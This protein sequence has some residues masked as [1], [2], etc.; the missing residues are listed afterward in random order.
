MFSTLFASTITCFRLSFRGAGLAL[1]AAVSRHRAVCIGLF[2]L[3]GPLSGCASGREVSDPSP[4]PEAEESAPV[5]ASDSGQDPGQDPLENYNRVV[6][7]F[8]DMVDVY[9][10]QPVARGYVRV[11]PVLLRRGVANFFDNL[12]YPNTIVNSFLQGKAEQGMLDTARFVFNCTAGLAGVLDVSTVF[13]LPG[14]GREDFGQTLA[15]WGVRSGFYLQIPLLGPSTPRRLFGVP[16][17]VALNPLAYADLS[18][19]APLTALRLVGARASLLKARKIQKDTAV[20][21]YIF[22]REAYRQQRRNLIYD[23]NVPLEE[24]E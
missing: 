2:A 16:M 11:A 14:R 8:N 4:V 18:D 3:L 10:L 23:G 22:I 15:V 13:G 19:T 5:A 21:D 20:D 24:F 7:Q 1:I 6:F 12:T 17:S 9:V